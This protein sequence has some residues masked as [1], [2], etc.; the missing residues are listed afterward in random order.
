MNW[1]K[2]DPTVLVIGM[3]SL[4]LGYL[5][6]LVVPENQSAPLV[7]V[8]LFVLSI[9]FNLAYL[10]RLFFQQRKPQL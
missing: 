5:I 6:G 7:Q 4:G 1:W 9:I 10:R 8:V 2:D 3:G